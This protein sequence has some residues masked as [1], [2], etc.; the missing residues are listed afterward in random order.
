MRTVHTVGN[1]CAELGRIFAGKLAPSAVRIPFDQTIR[2]LVRNTVVRA[3]VCM[4]SCVCANH[5][6]WLVGQ[7]YVVIHLSSVDCLCVEP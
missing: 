6:S 1:A 7:N 3:C 4:H 2:V 5:A